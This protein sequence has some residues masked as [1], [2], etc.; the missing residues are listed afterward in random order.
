MVNRDDAKIRVQQ[1]TDI[2][3]L[4]G[5]QVAL[6]P[7]GKEYVGLCP[8]HDDTN[9]SMYVVPSKQIYHCFSCGA[10]GDCFSF[11]M[12]YHKMNFADALRHLADRAGI[13]LPAPAAGDS[14]SQ[15]RSQR[16][17][18]LAANVQALRFFRNLLAHE[19]HGKIARDY[20]ADRGIDHAMIE[21]FQI[22]YASD[23]WDGLAKTAVHHGWAIQQLEQAGLLARRRN[24]EGYYDRFRHRLIF[25]I[26]DAMSRPIAFGGRV[27]P[28]GALDDNADAKYLNS[29]ENA[30]F[31]KSATLYGMHRAKQPI[32]RSHTA[33][34]VEGYTDVIAAHQAGFE[35]VVA[36]LGT[37]L[38]RDHARVLRHLCEQVV[39]IFDADEAG[40]K[41]ADR[42]LEVFF[43]EPLDVKIA[44]LPEGRDPADLFSSA[45]GGEQW[46]QTIDRAE[47]A[48]RFT[49]E[50]LRSRFHATDTMAGRQ[51]LAEQFIQRLA[52]L[53][54]GQAEPARRAMVLHHLSDLLR[55]DVATI[56]TMLRRAPGPRRES[57][58]PAAE[59]A[60]RLD[61]RALAERMIVGCLVSRPSL[62]HATMPDG[63]DL[64]E[65]VLPADLAH[66][67]TRRLYE[68]WH[69][70]LSQ[71]DAEPS[72]DLRSVL[73][74][75]ALVRMALD[76]RMEVD[77]LTD[78]EDE[79]VAQQ[80]T[81][82]YRSWRKLVDQQQY[83]W[84]KM[85]QQ[86][87]QPIDGDEARRLAQ[88]IEITRTHPDAGR[89]PRITK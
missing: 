54:L 63:R 17:Q 31:N 27:L 50:R 77:E 55:L 35:N 89:I 29:P 38:T 75:E 20:L 12:D 4:I 34:I 19:S 15:T 11:V 21:Q 81:A 44:I 83:Q 49:F 56:D 46:Q 80:L 78:A 32:I 45:Q 16:E 51:K 65:A 47:D 87:S 43:R 57:A 8:F 84:Q 26:L 64:S 3:A 30:L 37:A 60:P 13:E 2:V 72:P 62:F 18:I 41:A 28:G 42:A 48:I 23:R 76:L 6:K 24:G 73:N 67:P 88:A 40:Q 52:G 14:G 36:T 7:R 69:A 58:E 68:Q 82:A 9:P 1:A 79:R 86:P 59:A 5:D 25:P 53:G 10:G 39:L 74:E 61:A 22:G 70:S 71:T 33:V 66:E 85:Q